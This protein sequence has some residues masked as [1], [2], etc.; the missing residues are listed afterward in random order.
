M[1][2]TGPGGD[3]GGQY[4]WDSSPVHPRVDPTRPSPPHSPGGSSHRLSTYLFAEFHATPPRRS[5]NG[6]D[7]DWVHPRPSWGEVLIR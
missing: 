1:A 6:E 4:L 7:L 3:P 5:R 2:S